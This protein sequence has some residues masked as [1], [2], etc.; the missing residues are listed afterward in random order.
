MCVQFLINVCTNM[1]AFVL[2]YCESWVSTGP[3]FFVVGT[4]MC[5]YMHG[6]NFDDG[7]DV[8]VHS[9]I[10]SVS[11]CTCVCVLCI[12]LCVFCFGNSSVHVFDT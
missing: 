3:M 2:L 10:F 7:V 1:T 12:N 11:C 6:Y 4:C 9:L 5:L 8:G